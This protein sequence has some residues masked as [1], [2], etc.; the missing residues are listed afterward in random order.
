MFTSLYQETHR[1]SQ[2][3][4]KPPS[5]HLLPQSLTTL[6]EIMRS[7]GYVTLGVTDGGWMSAKMQFDQGFVVYD[8][9]GRAGIK[10]GADRLVALVD[11]YSWGGK[12]IFAFLHTYE[13]HSPYQ[14]PR[15]Y[16]GLFGPSTSTFVPNSQNL[17]RAHR[18][19]LR[20]G[21]KD[22]EFVR[23]QYDAGIRY[24]DDVLRDLFHRLD[25]LGFLDNCLVILTSDHGEALGERGHFLHPG[26]LYREL[27]NV[28]LIL[29]G[30]KIPRGKIDERLVSTIDIAP[31]VLDYLGI[32]IPDSFQGRSTLLPPTPLEEQIT[33]SQY[34]S[35]RYAASTRKWKL[36]RSAKTGS[37]RLFDRLADLH[38]KKNVVRQHRKVASRL[39]DRI[40]AWL[41]DQAPVEGQGQKVPH[42]TEKEIRRLKT[43]GYL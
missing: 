34:G 8:D 36:I 40:S 10:S 32:E 12:P 37:L 9:Q 7:A 22:I 30:P 25:E 16:R 15:E 1:V 43:L 24:T 33:F 35:S 23:S 20:L 4:R 39:N 2:N 21:V 19:V 41:A 17:Q 3:G 26:T 38:E 13:V 6:P 14:P 29:A 5:R 28:P 11:D 42:L 27:L 18:R 31:T